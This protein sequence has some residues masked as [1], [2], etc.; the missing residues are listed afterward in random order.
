MITNFKLFEN[1][2]NK[3]DTGYY[4]LINYNPSYHD[5]TSKKKFDDYFSKN[6]GNVM[7]VMLDTSM[8]NN[9]YHYTV[10]FHN[11]P[12]EIMHIFQ[13]DETNGYHI[14]VWENNI[15][16]YGKTLNEIK[17]KLS[18]KKFNI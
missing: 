13:Y 17:M 7:I 10:Q 14:N 9:N 6:I 11:I 1:N 2:E 16:Y 4:V 3:I 15:L 18:A 5:Q 12:D 8:R